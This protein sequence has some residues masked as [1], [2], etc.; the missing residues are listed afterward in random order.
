MSS[1][2]LTTIAL[3]C[4]FI[5]T[6]CSRPPD[7]LISEIGAETVSYDETVHMNNCGGKAD[8]EQT[9]TR[10]F[11]TSLE[12]GISPTF[13]VNFPVKSVPVDVQVALDAHYGQYRDTQKSIKV[14]APPGSNMEFSLRWSD[15]K[16]AGNVKVNDQESNYSVRVPISVDL[17]SSEDIGCSIA[18]IPT[19]TPGLSTLFSESFE[20]SSGN[21]SYDTNIWECSGKCDLAKFTQEQG[22]LKIKMNGQGGVNLGTHQQ[23]QLEN[24]KEISGKFKITQTGKGNGGAW[25]GFAGEFGGKPLGISCFIYPLN[26]LANCEV[27]REGVN[28]YGSKMVSIGDGWHVLRVEIDPNTLAFHFYV[29]N[30]SFGQFTPENVVNLNTVNLSANIGAYADTSDAQIDVFVDEVTVTGFNK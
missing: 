4:I 6:S 26:N 9:L 17:V 22:A 2:S 14:I 24:I 25:L 1:R 28:I 10:S 12:G 16:H 19:T 15:E 30:T 8:I 23:W 20:S 11:S 21:K 5:I 13:G 29:D 7:I 27:W 18:Q 3:I